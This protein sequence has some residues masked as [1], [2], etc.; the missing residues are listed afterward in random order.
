MSRSESGYTVI[1]LLIVAVI[2]GILAT[3]AISAFSNQRQRATLTQVKA[4][5]KNIAT[6]LET[7]QAEHA[8]YPPNLNSLTPEFM[9]KIPVQPVGNGSYRYCVSG[10]TVYELDTD[11]NEYGPS[12]SASEVFVASG[13]GV[14]EGNGTADSC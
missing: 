8:V 2:I 10:G 14:R 12:G 11:E 3:L 4:E 5:M 9:V 7:Y 6:A 13:S 1:E